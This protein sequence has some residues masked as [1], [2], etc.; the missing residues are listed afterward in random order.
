MSKASAIALA[1]FDRASAITTANGY[2]TNIGAT[3]YRGKIYLDT[4]SLPCF[5]LIEDDDEGQ[6][7]SVSRS[8][9]TTTYIL[10]GYASCDPDHP[11]DAGHLIVADLKKAIFGSD[12]TFGQGVTDI[13]WKGRAIEPREEGTTLVAARIRFALTYVENLAAP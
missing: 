8:L 7:R 1:I 10:E 3:G 13:A 2:A 12:L 4:E 9:T 6:S 5:V 11:N